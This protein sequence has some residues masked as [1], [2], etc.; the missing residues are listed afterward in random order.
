MQTEGVLGKSSKNKTLGCFLLLP[1]PS[2]RSSLESLCGDGD[3]AWLSHGASAHCIDKRSS[4]GWAQGSEPAT[5]SCCSI[6]EESTLARCQ[7]GA[8]TPL[9]QPSF[10]PHDH[11]GGI[12]L[13]RVLTW[14]LAVTF[15]GVS[16]QAGPV[17]GCRWVSTL[18]LHRPGWD[19][20]LDSTFS[21][22][23]VPSMEGTQLSDDFCCN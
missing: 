11:S 18:A 4:A 17:A 21:Y 20:L 9:I 15:G 2:T 1:F 6:L 16:P 23:Q 10:S 8:G 19:R 5:Q 3:A 12:S 14:L 13:K 7:A 22:P